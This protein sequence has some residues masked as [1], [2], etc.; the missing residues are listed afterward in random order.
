MLRSGTTTFTDM[1]F[2]PEH[3]AKV[4][5]KTGIRAIM[6]CPV[7]MFPTKWAS[8]PEEYLEK[9]M[10]LVKR[11]KDHNLV[12]MSLAPHAPYTVTDDQL[13]AINKL[14]LDLDCLV[15]MHVHETQGEVDTA[16]N[17]NG[18]SPLFRLKKHGLLRPKFLAVHM[19]SLTAEEIALVAE[20]GVSV[21]HCPESN[22]KLAS[23]FCPVHKLV[24]AGVN[25]SIGT[26]GAA[27]N[28]DLDMFGEMRTGERSRLAYAVRIRFLD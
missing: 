8:T 12:N 18:H 21:A 23:G 15:Q 7:M 28:N 1:Y 25:V 2:F 6:G 9:G 4:A 5:E 19:T 10:D 24:T 14:A 22:T 13:E 17:E 16:V 27:S 26:D 20:T 11:W 3:S